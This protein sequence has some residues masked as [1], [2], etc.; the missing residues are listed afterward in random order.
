MK[1]LSKHSTFAHVQA[2]FT[3]AL[4]LSFATPLCAQTLSPGVFSTLQ[5]GNGSEVT[6]YAYAA[7]GAWAKATDVYAI[8]MGYS[9]EATD[10]FA[11]AMGNSVQSTA[12]SSTA[13]GGFTQATA[14]FSTALGVRTIANSYASTVIG[15]NNK[16]LSRNAT[17]WIAT[18]PLFEVGNGTWNTPSNA[19]TL[20]K[21]GNMELQGTLSTGGALLAPSISTPGALTASSISATNLSAATITSGGQE[22]ITPANLATSITALPQVTVSGNS[23]L[24]GALNAAGNVQLGATGQPLTGMPSNVTGAYY[25]SIKTGSG[26]YEHDLSFQSTGDENTGDFIVPLG[27]YI[28]NGAEIK[29]D[30]ATGYGDPDAGSAHYTLAGKRHTGS[31]NHQG[32]LIAL[33]HRA[34]GGGAGVELYGVNHHGYAFL[35]LKFDAQ[36]YGPGQVMDHYLQVKITSTGLS[37]PERRDGTPFDQTYLIK[38]VDSTSRPNNSAITKLINA[39]QIQLNGKVTLSAPQGDIAM[40]IFQ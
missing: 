26:F 36:N 40:G 16:V 29:I 14:N 1:Q 39:D 11:V 8:A 30:I 35:Y 33:E 10:D 18:E 9:A 13:M 22:V 38:K 6:G 7:M 25:G 3:A 23:N 17:E 31:G 5:V 32:D 2:S 34:A 37:F 12:Y 24:N 20:Y 27:Y 21:N 28:N 19:L 15:S 4:G